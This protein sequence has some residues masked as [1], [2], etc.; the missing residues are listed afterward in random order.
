MTFQSISEAYLRELDDFH[1]EAQRVGEMTAEL[2]YR[3]LLDN[4]LGEISATFGD[5]V[6][7]VFE[8]RQQAKAGRPDWRFYD[9]DS[10][11]LYGYVEAKGLSDGPILV[12][13]YVEQVSKYLTLGYRVVLTDGLE[14]VF[15]EPSDR[16]TTSFYLVDKA[17]KGHF[18]DR[19]SSD[20]PLLEGA[21]HRFFG[22]IAARSI[23]EQ[24]LVSECA[25]RARYLAGE[26]EVLAD[27]PAG[28]GF[29]DRENDAI[30]ILKQLRAIV[31]KHH[32]PLL[33]DKKTFSGFVAQTLIFG[34]IYAHRVLGVEDLKPAERYASLKQFWLD[35]AT[36]GFASALRPFRALTQLLRDEIDSVGDLGIWYENCCLMLSHVQLREEQVAEPDYH[37]LFERFLEAFDPQTRFDYGAFYTPKE[38]SGYAVALVEELNGRIFNGSI[39]DKGNRLIDPCC[40]TGSFLDRLLSASVRSGGGASLIGFEILPAPYALANYRM[41]RISSEY[42]GVSI[43]LT[44]TLSDSIESDPPAGCQANLFADEQQ[45]AR[46]LAKPPLVLVIGNPPSS[47]SFSHSNGPG[48][49]IIQTLLEDFRPPAEDRTGRQN[50]QK[51]TQNEFMKFLRWSGNKGLAT[52]NSIVALI[53]PSTFAENTSYKFARKWFI[54]NFHDFWVLD[55]D[56]DARTGVRSSNVFRTLQ[57]RLLFVAIRRREQPLADGP[58]TYNYLSIADFGLDEKNAFFDLATDAGEVMLDQFESL[59]LDQSKPVFRPQ[60]LF[61]SEVYDNFWPLLKTEG[62]ENYI[63]ERHCSGLKLAP[64]SFFI[65]ADAPVL[66]R[67]TGEIADAA[68]TPADIITRWYK[69]QSKPPQTTKFSAPVRTALANEIAGDPAGAIGTY[70]YR[71]FL[72]LPA[73]I[74]ENVLSVLAKAPG[75]GTRYRPEILAAYRD[76]RTMGIAVAPAPKDLGDSLHRF[77]S[78]CWYPPDNDLCKRGNAHVLCNYFPEYKERR[79]NWNSAPQLNINRGFLTAIGSESPDRVVFYVYGILCSNAYLDAFEPALFT[80]AGDQP[81]RVP[82]PPDLETFEAISVLG[83]ELAQLEK[84]VPDEDLYIAEVYRPYLE[85]LENDFKVTSFRIDEEG[86]SLTLLAGTNEFT[87]RPIPRD[88][89]EFQIGGYQVLQQWLKV[90]TNTYTRTAFTQAHLK[91]LLHTLHSM[92]QQ[93]AAINRLDRLVQPLVAR[94]D[95]AE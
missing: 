33:R 94:L 26:I 40:G 27:L 84:H 81:P 15:F 20:L 17:S 2:S 49:S 28:S 51:Q 95:R 5:N 30:E 76:E 70:A 82:L 63:F 61:N 13:E 19:I 29:S 85:R 9:K 50:T 69:G 60:K 64:T 6:S 8:P 14:F 18:F 55:I 57:G 78:F 67:R 91:R 38:L 62:E 68:I 66:Q 88:I 44:N 72:N 52:G 73:L 80:T 90:H 48:F 10:L 36:D 37:E 41:V 79:A 93:V 21:F 16:S 23:A 1:R 45:T 11:G 87:I 22:D 54:D 39:Y 12:D 35:G 31:E 58:R 46:E 59:E 92:S 89:L 83:E 75:K 34:L 32:D 3:P 71:P 53:L 86:E 74:S 42:E 65:H 4:F 7:R 47:D 56:K 43:V 25:L 24:Q 77:A